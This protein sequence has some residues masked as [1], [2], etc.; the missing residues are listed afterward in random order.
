MQQELKAKSNSTPQIGSD[1]NTVRRIILIS[2]L[3][4][5]IIACL[6]ALLRIL[7]FSSF[8]I[9]YNNLIHAHS[10]GAFLGWLFLANFAITGYLIQYKLSTKVIVCLAADVLLLLLTVPLFVK[11]GY[12][13]I[14]IILSTLHVI[15]STF[16]ALQLIKQIGFKNLRSF[17]GY[18]SYLVLAWICLIISG[19]FPLI[20][21]IIVKS[22]GNASPAYY[23]TIYTYLHFQYNGFFVSSILAIIHFYLGS[24]NDMKLKIA[25]HL[26]A[27]SVPLTL[28]NSYLWCAPGFW[29]NVISTVACVMQLTACMFLLNIKSLLQS[30]ENRIPFSLNW[31]IY[32]LILKS[33]MQFVVSFPYVAVAS[34]SNRYLILFYLHFVLLGII[35]I[36]IIKMTASIL[37]ITNIFYYRIAINVLKLVFLITQALM[38]YKAAEMEGLF[39]YSNLTLPFLAIISIL[40]PLILVTVLIVSLIEKPKVS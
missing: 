29:F 8:S 31:V 35:S 34:Y 26:F 40:F 9:S 27:L 19:I 28:T 14:T 13:Y 20:L 10:H 33:I 25:Y 1:N 32:G 24:V 23:N 22:F 16:L 7:P 38:A 36:T 4:L 17:N 18:K 3:F 5:V 15:L 37:N 30:L 2:Y 11:Y 39:H 12:N 6:G 21:G